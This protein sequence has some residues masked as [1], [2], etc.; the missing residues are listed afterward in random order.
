M[1]TFRS[2]VAALSLAFTAPLAFVASSPI[3]LAQNA[4]PDQPQ[5][6]VK[7]IALTDK[8]I[9]E[10]LAA[11][12]D[13]DPVLAKLPQD[14]QPDAKA[15]A[16]LDAVAKKHGFADYA[17]YDLVGGN[18]GLV[19]AGIDPQS[20]KYVGPEAVL[21]A[22]IAEVQADKKMS[23]KDKKDALDQ[24]NAELK[25]TVPVQNQGN[26]TLVIKYYDKLAETMQQ[27]G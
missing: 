19:I 5:E 7:Q 20:K 15:M 3:A 14:A 22:Q 4:Q 12:K 10:F 26:I 24:L 13:M 27:H 23:Q 1:R 2:Y 9:S 21:K 6:A 16:Q 8:Q 18:I 25:S 17:E 11:Q